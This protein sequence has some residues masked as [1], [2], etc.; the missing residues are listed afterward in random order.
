MPYVN[1]IHFIYNEKIGAGYVNLS[2]DYTKYSVKAG[3]RAEYTWSNSTADS[4]NTV[5]DNSNHYLDLFPSLFI[6]H[7]IDDKDEINFSYGRRID[8]PQYD[9]LNPFTYH[10]DPYTFLKGNPYLKPQY[11]NNFQ[12]NYTYNHNITLTF[13]YTH[14]KDMFAMVPVTDPA[15]KSLTR[16]RKT[17]NHK[18]ATP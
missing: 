5:Q 9:N 3:L 10:F 16:P 18:I 15:T 6:S 12:F 17:C 7:K 8:R 1:E 4:V 14:L 2:K 11:A 13:G